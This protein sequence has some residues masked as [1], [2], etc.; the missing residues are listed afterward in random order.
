MHHMHIQQQGDERP[1]RDVRDGTN[2]DEEEE[3]KEE[4]KDTWSVRDVCS[5]NVCVL[6]CLRYFP[7]RGSL[8]S[9]ERARC[10]SAC[11]R[12]RVEVLF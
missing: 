11:R 2:K 6:N 1:V 7:P 3:T 4:G 5:V 9:A 10:G 12:C 8:V